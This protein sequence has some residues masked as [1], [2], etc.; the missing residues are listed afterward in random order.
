LVAYKF[1]H[2]KVEAGYLR[3]A[4]V[5]FSVFNALNDRHEEHPFGDTIGSLVMS[6]LTVRF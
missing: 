2:E 3:E 1:W 6:W 4:E 5:T